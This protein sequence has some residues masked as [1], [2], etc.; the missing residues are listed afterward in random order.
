MI[1]EKDLPSFVAVLAGLGVVNLAVPLLPSP[2]GSISL[3]VVAG[4][5]MTAVIMLSVAAFLAARFRSALTRTLRIG[6]GLILGLGVAT[7]GTVEWGMISRGAI[8]GFLPVLL[9][10]FLAALVGGRVR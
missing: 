7:L 3:E 8:L 10:P 5:A 9:V 1:T 6:L 2:N 4:R